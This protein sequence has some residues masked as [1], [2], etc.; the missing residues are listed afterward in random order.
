MDNKIIV[1]R[2]R[3]LIEESLIPLIKKDYVF[4]D[5]PYHPNVGD[6]LIAMGAMEL[7][8]KT[9]R[10]CLYKSSEFTYD[11]RSLEKDTLI[12]FNGGGN[13]GDLWMPYTRFRNQI[14]S[15]YPNN[16]I[17]IMPQSVWYSKKENLNLDK[18]IYDNCPNITICARDEQSFDFLL[19]NFEN[20]NVLL[21]PDLAFYTSP[22]LL[23]QRESTGRTL[24]LRRDDKE[25]VDST[26]YSAVPNIAEVHDWPTLEKGDDTYK[27]YYLFNEVNARFEKYVNKRIAWKLKDLYWQKKLLPYNVKKGIEFVNNYDVIYSTRLHVAVLGFLLNKQVFFFDNN[28]GKNSALFNTWLHESDKIKML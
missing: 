7:L 28:Y 27:I 23:I 15:K 8:S 12:V 26:R 1:D 17:L 20:N 10:K 19:K 16:Q 25:Y 14:I 11:G 5:L 21:I 6:T 4:L 22:S 18:S 9:G 13:F 3:K 24:F 2:L